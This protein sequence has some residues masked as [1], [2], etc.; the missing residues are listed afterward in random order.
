M[1]L[2]IWFTRYTFLCLCFVQSAS[3]GCTNIFGGIDKKGK[4]IASY[5]KRND[6]R[7][8]TIAKTIY[9]QPLPARRLVCKDEPLSLWEERKSIKAL[10]YPVYV[11]PWA[12]GRWNGNGHVPRHLLHGRK[13][14]A[15]ESRKSLVLLFIHSVAYFLFSEKSMFCMAVWESVIGENWLKRKAKAGNS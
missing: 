7:Y 10:G 6:F 11:A 5:R 1:Y 14:S 3:V 12:D 8:E 9:G 13:S 4:K 2:Q 15:T